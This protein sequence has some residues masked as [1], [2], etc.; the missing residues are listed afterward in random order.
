[1]FQQQAWSLESFFSILVPIIILLSMIIITIT[2]ILVNKVQWHSCFWLARVWS[3]GSRVKGQ[4][5][6]LHQRVEGVDGRQVG[7]D[8]DVLVPPWRLDVHGYGA[9][10]HVAV[11]VCHHAGGEGHVGQPALAVV[12]GWTMTTEM[13]K[14]LKSSS[15]SFS[16]LKDWNNKQR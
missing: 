15:D 4:V 1:M 7:G 6:T 10:R 8:G 12:A 14:K 9:G 11:Q 2:T 16:W 5:L 3:Q 13:K